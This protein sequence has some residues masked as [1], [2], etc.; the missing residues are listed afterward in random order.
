MTAA[1]MLLVESGMRKW[2]ECR[3][4]QSTLTPE[5]VEALADC[6]WEDMLRNLLLVQEFYYGIL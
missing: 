6:M 1:T 4:N 3:G 5:E 2:H